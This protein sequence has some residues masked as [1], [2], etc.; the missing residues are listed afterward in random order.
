MIH[1]SDDLKDALDKVVWDDDG[2]NWSFAPDTPQHVI[3]AWNE[4]QELIEEGE[5]EG[6]QIY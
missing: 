2:E 5:A 4:I 1:F 6:L 3:D